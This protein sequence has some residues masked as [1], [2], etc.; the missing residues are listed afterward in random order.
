MTL[1]DRVEGR[2][3]WL[4]GLAAARVYRSERLRVCA[5]PPH[6]CLSIVRLLFDARIPRVCSSSPRDVFQTS[7]DAR[8]RGKRAAPRARDR[9]R[10]KLEHRAP[11][12]IVAHLPGAASARTPE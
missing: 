6:S 9:L 12:S 7:G 1:T 11:H 4:G 2:P 3:G 10:T 8:E 5:R